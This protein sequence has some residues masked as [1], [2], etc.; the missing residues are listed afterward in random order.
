M[1]ETVPPDQ[2]SSHFAM[3]LQELVRVRE[4]LHTE[5]SLDSHEGPELVKRAC[6]LPPQTY[7]LGE[8]WKPE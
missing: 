3:E 4:R 5:T 8:P 7:N 6:S 2:G 1:P